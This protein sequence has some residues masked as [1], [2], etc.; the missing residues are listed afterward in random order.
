VWA[1][2]H[3]FTRR[4]DAEGRKYALLNCFSSLGKYS[5]GLLMQNKD[6]R[7]LDG[8]RSGISVHGLERR[9]SWLETPA[10][11]LQ[12]ISF[13]CGCS[14][15]SVCREPLETSMRV[16]F[17][18]SEIRKQSENERPWHLPNVTSS[19]GCLPFIDQGCRTP[20]PYPPKKIEVLTTQPRWLTFGH[21]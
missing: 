17:R 12:C 13:C 19:F 8:L 1:Q 7:G 21:Q 20:T 3:I 14:H 18:V 4:L 11:T 9:R 10:A 6:G 2:P 5:V 15:S 16:S